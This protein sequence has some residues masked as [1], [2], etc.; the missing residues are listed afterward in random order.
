[1]VVLLEGYPISTEELWSSVRATI[2]FLVTSLTMALLPRLLNLARRPALGRVLVVPI[3]FHLRMMKPLCSVGPSMLQTFFGPD[4]CLKTFLTLSSTDNSSYK[5]SIVS[6][7][8]LCFVSSLFICLYLIL[9][10]FTELL[11]K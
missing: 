1:M 2:G 9:V 4:L 10:A 8:L 5:S 11:S 7:Q 3:F 6:E